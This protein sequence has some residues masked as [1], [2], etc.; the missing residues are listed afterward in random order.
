MAE[1]LR[2]QN[3]RQA[4]PAAEEP[5]I[6]NPRIV[7]GIREDEKK[8]FL[9]RQSML[10]TLRELELK[11]QENELRLEKGQR[12]NAKLDRLRDRLRERHGELLQ[13]QA[14]R[15]ELITKV[16]HQRFRMES[17]ES[18]KLN[19][20]MLLSRRTTFIDKLE[21][22]TYEQ[23]LVQTRLNEQIESYLQNLRALLQMEELAISEGAHQI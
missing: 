5:Q 15:D 7:N 12:I 9:T 2:K 17:A 21:N 22:D 6:C 16:D 3:E 19:D 11:Q 20:S 10:E 18:D 1:Y 4:Q 8:L 13:L 23:A 14:Q